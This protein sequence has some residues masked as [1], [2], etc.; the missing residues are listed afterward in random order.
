M[1]NGGVRQ[2]V[3]R[4]RRVQDGQPLR[5]AIQAFHCKFIEVPP[6]ED[7]ARRRAEVKEAAAWV[8]GQY[9]VD[10]MTFALS[11]LCQRWGH[12]VFNLQCGVLSA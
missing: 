5:E 4:A 6:N 7:K 11:L 1:P 10:I 2:D 3:L 12:L 8:G 9:I